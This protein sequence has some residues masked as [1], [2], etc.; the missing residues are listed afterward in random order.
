MK[1]TFL[2]PVI[3]LSLV[4]SLVACNKDNDDDNGT[5][6]SDQQ[7][8]MK[9]A[10]ANIAEV[11]AGQLAATKGNKA[12]I[13]M[14]GNM[15]VTDHTQAFFELKA[16]ADSMNFTLPSSPDSAHIVLKQQLTALNGTAFDSLYINSQVSDHQKAIALF[17]TQASGGF[18]I[19]LK[20]YANKYL[21]GLR[22]HLR[23]AD[24][25]RALK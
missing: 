1:R 24:S 9:A 11:D 7:F 8:M 3:A 19:R 23:M 2:I 4:I 16:L 18:D 14:F 6:Q 21:P 12:A 20:N 13:K 15:M 25:I 22:M 10:Q 17:E 5:P